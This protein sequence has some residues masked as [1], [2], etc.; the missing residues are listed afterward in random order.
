LLSKSVEIR[1]VVGDCPDCHL[2]PLAAQF[3]FVF[4]LHNLL[5]AEKYPKSKI[6]SYKLDRY[7]STGF[8]KIVALDRI[9]L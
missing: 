1:C 4:I 5:E 3:F 9:L 6:N 2:L 7:V 8:I